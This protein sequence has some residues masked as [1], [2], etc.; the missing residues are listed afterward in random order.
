MVV[1]S[2][3]VPLIVMCVCTAVCQAKEPKQGTPVAG[4]PWVDNV[5]LPDSVSLCGEAVPIERQAVR[6]RLDREFTILVWDKPQVFLWLKRAN[7]Y[8]PYIEKQ[9]AQAGMPDDLKYL[10]VA[11]SSLLT[12]ALSPAGAGGYW[13]FMP[14]TA[15]E[16]GLKKN[17]LTDERYSLEHSTAAALTYL[18]ECHDMFGSWSLAMAAYNCGERRVQ[19][20]IE[21]QK[22]DDYYRL[23]LPMETERYVFRIAAIKILLEN[24]EQYG[25][26]IEPEEL[27]PPAEYDTLDLN[28]PYELQ[29]ADIANAAGTDYKT[30]RD[31]NPQLKNYYFPAGAYTIKVPA[32][33]RKKFSKEVARSAAAAEKR[34]RSQKAYYIVKRGDTLGHI[35]QRTGVPIKTLKRLNGIR[36]STIYPGQKLRLRP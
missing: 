34:A 33:L 35:A 26:R 6:E 23:K 2:L 9:L 24:P 16:K 29:I 30:I 36:G 21:D 27:Y 10:A 4:L 19:R 18:K 8:F 14:K 3:I 11:E 12:H 13:Q 5:P 31:L 15:K 17:S 20:A 28:S 7:R 25:Y 1:R 32:G 22:V